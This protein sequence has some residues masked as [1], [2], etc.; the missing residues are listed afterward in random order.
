MW[1]YDTERSTSLRRDT[2]VKIIFILGTGGFLW[3]PWHWDDV[4]WRICGCNQVNFRWKKPYEQKYE[5]GK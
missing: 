1:L 5:Y 4:Y 2:W 3:K